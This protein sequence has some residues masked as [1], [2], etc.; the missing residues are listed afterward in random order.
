R[1]RQL[2][3]QLLLLLRQL[4]RRVDPDRDQQIAVAAT[5]DVRHALAAHT[6]RRAALRAGGNRELLIAVERR[7]LD[8]ASE[9]ERGEV[10][11]N[12]AVQV[13]AVSLEKRMLLHVHD[14]VEIARR[15][16]ARTRFTFT[17]EAQPLSRGDAGRDAD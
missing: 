16:A 6:E 17:T 9:R 5:A 8:L 11:W 3:E 4:L 12:L 10:E 14:D 1:R 15:A 2:F 13:V 7:N